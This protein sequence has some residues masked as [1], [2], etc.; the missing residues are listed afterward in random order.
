MLHCCRDSELTKHFL[1]S[2]C[3]IQEAVIILLRAIYLGQSHGCACHAPAVYDQVEGL[4]VTELKTT[5]IW[6]EKNH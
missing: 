4:C 6:R 3:D 1:R 2:V 5:P